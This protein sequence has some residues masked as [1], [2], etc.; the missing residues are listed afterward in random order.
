MIMKLN[1]DTFCRAGRPDRWRQGTMP[2]INDLLLA[3]PD[4]P[5]TTHLNNFHVRFLQIAD[6]NPETLV[7]I[8]RM[9]NGP[10]KVTKSK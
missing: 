10:S 7:S 3:P 4:A 9:R 8:A 5:I 6:C 2:D 1:E